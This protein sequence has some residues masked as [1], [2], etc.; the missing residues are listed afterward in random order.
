MKQTKRDIYLEKKADDILRM[1]DKNLSSNIDAEVQKR[2]EDILIHVYLKSTTQTNKI[3]KALTTTENYL[4]IM[5][6]KVRIAF[7]EDRVIFAVN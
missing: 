5:F 7:F 4:Q 2:N 6:K 1:L 3:I